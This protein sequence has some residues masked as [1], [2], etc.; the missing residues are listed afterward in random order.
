MR[1]RIFVTLQAKTNLIGYYEYAAE[2]APEAAA[3]WLD[4]FE[5]AIES[6]ADNPER[7][8]RAA[9]SDAVGILIRQLLVGRARNVYRVLFTITGHNVTVLHIRRGVMD[10]ASAADLFGDG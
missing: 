1:Y 7:C 8:G 6:L 10:Q 2:R 5:E 3:R 9:E 4:R